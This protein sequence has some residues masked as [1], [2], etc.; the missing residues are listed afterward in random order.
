LFN[1]NKNNFKENGR[2]ILEIRN[3]KIPILFS[4]ML[5]WQRALD[6]HSFRRLIRIIK[7][8]VKI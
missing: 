3:N 4:W 2:D 7:K 5:T 8:I 6:N 1:I